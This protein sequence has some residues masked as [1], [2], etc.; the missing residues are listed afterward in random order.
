MTCLLSHRI[1]KS[2]APNPSMTQLSR[3][4]ARGSTGTANT[5]LV[6]PSTASTLKRLEPI[7]LL[8]AISCS[9]RRAATMEVTSSGKLVPMAMMVRPMTRSETPIDFAMV[10]APFTRNS[11]PIH[12]PTIPATTY[13][14]PRPQARP[15]LPPS[16][17]RPSISALREEWSAGPAARVCRTVSTMN[18][19]SPKSSTAPSIRLI[20]PSRAMNRNSTNT[21]NMPGCSSSRVLREIKTGFTRAAPAR[22]TAMLKMLEPTTLAYAMAVDP[23]AAALTLTASSGR[24]VPKA[25]TVRPTTAVEILAKK[26]IDTAPRTM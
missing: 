11:A 4:M 3:L 15:R 5:K 23:A 10:T 20:N 21:A 18:N 1:G 7:K 14:M 13:A 2:A 25:T 16:G 9:P 26:A 19:T 8:S 24:L 6:R 17:C 12:N 22:M